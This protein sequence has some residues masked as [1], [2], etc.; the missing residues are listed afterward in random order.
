[1]LTGRRT[2]GF[3]LLEKMAKEGVIQ[4]K[5]EG[6]EVSVAEIAAAVCLSF[7]DARQVEWRNGRGELEKIY[8]SWETRESFVRAVGT[9]EADWERAKL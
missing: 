3:D 4:A 6:D 5:Q 2:R 8:Q 9:R 7:F 1:M